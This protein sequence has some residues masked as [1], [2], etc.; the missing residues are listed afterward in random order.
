L[1]FKGH[2]ESEKTTPECGKIFVIPMPDEKF[3]QEDI[4]SQHNSFFKNPITKWAQDLNK[5][6][7]KKDTQMANTHIKRCLIS[8]RK[9]EKRSCNHF[10]LIRIVIIK[11]Q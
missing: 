1:Y 5:H 2:Q 10:I 3:D 11:R 9:Q 4:V 8:K 6:F 7:S